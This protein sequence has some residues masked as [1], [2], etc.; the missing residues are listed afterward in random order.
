MVVL[1]CSVLELKRV[2]GGFDLVGL[3]FVVWCFVC[4]ECFG[5]GFMI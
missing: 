2:V 1:I 3:A 4:F 5:C